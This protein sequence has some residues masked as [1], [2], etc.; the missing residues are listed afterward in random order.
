MF[1]ACAI[2]AALAALYVLRVAPSPHTANASV[3]MWYK[4]VSTQQLLAMFNS[5]AIVKINLLYLISRF[6]LP[7]RT[8]QHQQYL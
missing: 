8:C 1:T 3:P 4:T 5:P 7:V 2:A 6:L